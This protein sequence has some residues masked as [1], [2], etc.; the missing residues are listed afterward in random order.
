MVR[1]TLTTRLFI[2]VGISVLLAGC[3]KPPESLVDDLKEPDQTSSLAAGSEQNT[4]TTT[5]ADSIVTQVDI[6]ADAN[7]QQVVKRFLRALQ[8]GDEQVVGG[9]LT[10]QARQATQQHNLVVRPPGTESATFQIGTA[11]E[12][13]GGAYVNCVWTESVGGGVSESFEIIWVLR[14]QSDG[15]RIVGMATQVIPNERPTFLN[16][17]EPAEMLSKWRKIDDTM[18]GRPSTGTRTA[19]DPRDRLRR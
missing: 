8:E 1:P 9:L 7:P 15:W 16:F 17:E 13:D 10:T 12:V 18:S 19:S 5:V 3:Q 4:G 14:N 2:F 6:S 11:E